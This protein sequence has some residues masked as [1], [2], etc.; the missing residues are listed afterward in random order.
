MLELTLKDPE[1]DPHSTDFVQLEQRYF[2]S[3]V[4]FKEVGDKERRRI[5]NIP[6]NS[7]AFKA[8]SHVNQP[9]Q[10]DAVLAGISPTLIEGNFAKSV[11]DNVNIKDVIHIDVRQ[12]S[13]MT[14]KRAYPVT[15]EDLVIR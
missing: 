8:E 9:S 5:Y 1:W 10:S 2:D 15:P 3:L 12:A 11:R 13:A 7:L 4:R 14:G 6:Q